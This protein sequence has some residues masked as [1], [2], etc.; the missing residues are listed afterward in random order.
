M[1]DMLNLNASMAVSIICWPLFHN[2]DCKKAKVN[3]SAHNVEMPL[4][5]SRRLID[6]ISLGESCR[7]KE[8][9]KQSLQ[10]RMKDPKN[11]STN[12]PLELGGKIAKQ[13]LQIFHR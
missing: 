2:S 6:F 13:L 11:T 5:H 10:N 9:V 12:S 1:C 4:S 8:G 3:T 7:T